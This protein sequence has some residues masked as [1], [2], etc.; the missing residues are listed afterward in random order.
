MAPP[1][2]ASSRANWADDEEFDDPSAL[3]PQQIVSNADGTKTIITYRLNDAGKKIKTSRKIRTTVVKEHVNPRVAE[4]KDWP[5]FGAEKGHPPGPDL[6]TTSV[7]E[8]I[9]F[10]PSTNWKA[11][12][13]EEEAPE[14]KLKD[15]LKDKK[16]ACR[17]CKGDHFTARCP[18]KDTLPPM[19]DVAAADSPAADTGAA[20]TGA[21]A[22]HDANGR[23]IAPHMRK[24]AR[25]AGE[26]MAGSGGFNNRDRD[27]LAT[28]RV[29][30]VSDQAEEDELRALFERFGRVTRVF[31]AKD[32]DTN[33]AK[34]F[35]FV[36]Y[37]DRGDAAKACE[38]LD[39]FGYRHLILRVEFAK[40]SA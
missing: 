15:Q 35:A 29:T 20:D 5:K 39:G 33:R 23:Y 13:K 30:N 32:R 28:L 26:S 37:N 31:L 40:R 14:N 12:Q 17:I 11:S 4:R 7:G 25:G 36:S 21:S 1:D 16:V 6:S 38:K 2:L 18:F 19:D 8:N 10:R 27:D 24:G 9:I 22:T 34:G 3:P